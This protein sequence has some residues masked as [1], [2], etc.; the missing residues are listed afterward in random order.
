MTARSIGYTAAVACVLSLPFSAHA[1]HRGANDLPYSQSMDHPLDAP[2][3]EA[4][5]GKCFF[6]NLGPTGIRARIDPEEPKA[7]KV[8]YVFQDRKSPARGLIKKG[9][10]IIGANGKRFRDPHGF[11]R[12]RAGAR[13]WQGPPFELALAIEDSQ[14]RD[15]KLEL[16]VYP[17]GERQKETVTIQLDPVGRFSETYPWNCPRSEKLL[18]GLCDFLI[19]YGVRGRHHYQVQQLLALWASGDKRA[20]PLVKAKAESLMRRPVSYKATGMCTWGWG[21]SGI[22]LGEYYNMTKDRDVKPAVEALVKAFEVGMDYRSGGFSHRPFPAIEQRIAAGGPKG[23]GAMAGPGGLSMLAQSIFK[24]TGLPYSEKAYNRTHLAYLQTAGGNAK[25]SIAYGFAGWPSLLIR[26]RSRTSPCKSTEGIGYICPTGMKNI[27]KIEAERW[28][29]EAG[30][31]NM[32][33]VSPKNYPWLTSEAEDIYVFD[34]RHYVKD[35]SKQRMVVRPMDL[36][37]PTRP[38][39]TQPGGGGH[40]APMG[41][42]AVAHS[43]GNKGHVPW[44]YLGEHLAAG[45]ALSPGMMFDGHADA[46]MHSFFSVLGA[47]RAEEEHFRSYLDYAKT[48]IVLS[49]PHDGQGLVDQPFGCQRNATCSISRDRTAYTH[50]AI[51]LLSL[52]R[53]NLLIT[54]A[55]TDAPQEKTDT[56]L[57]R[58]STWPTEPAVRPARRLSP[59]RRTRIDGALLRILTALDEKDALKR[60]PLRISVTR[61]QVWLAQADEGGELVFRLVEGEHAAAV[62]WTD[63]VAADRATLALLVATLRPDS[64]DAQALA[65]VYLELAGRVP[66]ADRYYEKAGETSSAKFEQLFESGAR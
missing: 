49:E 63:L 34:V 19:D 8:M 43:I 48:W 23:Y 28:T 17:A 45:C 46:T 29:Q 56:G 24:A 59:A 35:G 58:P 44:N 20:K 25:A 1:I 57:R 16:M 66:Q 13:G 64:Q 47:A 10:L 22:F 39:D 30:K 55:D 9:D 32:E 6:M 31:W 53:R 21:Y 15:G 36:S 51:L 52:P 62:P 27:G 7:F 65:G 18:E 12:K 41:M 4:F 11:H 26:L 40:V 5:D 3:N 14:G 60:V 50:T 54:G 33:L 38:Y 61:S 2:L 37:E 42:G